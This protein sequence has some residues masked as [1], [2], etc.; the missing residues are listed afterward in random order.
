[1]AEFWPGETRIDALRIHAAFAESPE[2][3]RSVAKSIRPQRDGLIVPAQSP[4]PVGARIVKLDQRLTRVGVGAHEWGEALEFVVPP[5]AATSA[6]NRAARASLTLPHAG[7]RPWAPAHLCA[8]RSASGDVAIS[9]VRCA[10]IGGDSWGLGEPPLGFPA[11][12]YVLEILD[13]GLPI[14]TL[15]TAVPS[16]NCSAAAQTT[17]FGS[18]PGSLHIRVAQI[19]ESGATGLNTE[20]TITL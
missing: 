14:R 20:L 10:R 13:S 16:F 18:L 5:A 8:R 15:S 6:S 2:V 12:G 4:H 3:S 9:W 11:E 1:M 17:D 19:G 7:L